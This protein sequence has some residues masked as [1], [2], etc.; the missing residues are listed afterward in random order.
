MNARTPDRPRALMPLISICLSELRRDVDQLT[1]SRWARV[2]LARARELIGILEE[3]C[4]RQQLD[5]LESLFR[6]MRGLVNVAREEA[7]PI[8]PEIRA[9]LAELLGSAE[10]VVSQD[11]RRERA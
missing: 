8:L 9:T 4:A 6:S 1:R 7:L 5:S 3:A 10:K 11:L 2:P